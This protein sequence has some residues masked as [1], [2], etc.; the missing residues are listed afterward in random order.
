MDWR[1]RRIVDNIWGPSGSVILHIILLAVLVNFVTLHRRSTERNVEVI[2][3]EIETPEDLEDLEEEIE[4][5]DDIPTVEDAVEPPTVS[6]EQEPPQVDTMS[7][8]EDFDMDQLDIVEATSPL[9]FKNLYAGRSAAGRSS[10]L[11]S[12]S[13]GMGKMTEYAVL[14]ALKWLRDHQYPDGSWG[15]SY[16]AAMTGLALLTLFAHGE[17]TASEEYGPTICKG[18]KYLL[19]RQQKGVFVGGGPYHRG[20]T[21]DNKGQIKAYEHAIATYAI[22][23]AYGLTSIPFLKESMEEAIQVIIDGQHAAGSWDYNYIHGPD[24]QVDVSLA[25]WHIQALKAA[26][27]A[28]AENRGLSTSIDSSIRGLKAMWA[29]KLGM[30]QYSARADKA[31]DRSM[32]GVAVLCM[33]LVGHA[34]DSEAK[35]GMTT[36][37]NTS[38]RW[39]KGEVPKEDKR[40]VGEW[41]LYAWYYITQARFHQGA[42]AWSTWNKQFAPVLCRMQNYDGSWCPA[43]DSEEAM[44]G[45][46]YCTCLSTLMLEVYYRFLPTY[47]EIK[48]DAGGETDVES[49]EDDI[50]IKFG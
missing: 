16:R 20:Y 1:T 5:I 50:V 47:K 22:S 6:L 10:A 31:P 39:T 44:F 33:Q 29:S 45:P 24:A 32:T 30:F 3:R 42:R 34:L 18:L 36:L 21:V 8:S 48:V 11:R 7:S 17:T 35:T 9:R 49:T 19:K 15:P 27:M 46:V 13:G 14:K 41:P 25:G 26:K 37:R 4:E 28:G 2:I 40:G 38:F 12:Y 43:P 23:E